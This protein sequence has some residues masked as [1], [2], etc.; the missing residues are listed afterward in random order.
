LGAGRRGRVTYGFT[1]AELLIAIGIFALVMALL[2]LPLF[3]AFGY[4]QKA[5]ARSEAQRAGIKAIR[6]FSRDIGTAQYLFDIPPDGSW[7]AFLKEQ[8]T[9]APDSTDADVRAARS[10]GMPMDFADKVTL[11]RYALTPAFPWVWGKDPV[12]NKD[13]WLL[14]TPTYLAAQ[15]LPV[16]AP[17]LSTQSYDENYAPYHDANRMGLTPNPYTITRLETEPLLWRDAVTAAQN[18]RYPLDAATSDL[19]GADPSTLPQRVAR[20][21]LI[22][23]LRN[24]LP[25]I[26]PYGADTWD[27][28]TFQVTPLRVTSEALIPDRLP[29][30]RVDVT[31]FSASRPLWVG[32]SLDLDLAD[33]ADFADAYLPPGTTLAAADIWTMATEAAP[34]YPRGV[35]PFGYQV[36]IFNGSGELQYG[37]S[38]YNAKTK[39]APLLCLRHFLDWPLIDR[40][41][42][43]ETSSAPNAV[44]LDKFVPETYGTTLPNPWQTQSDRALVS[45]ALR[46][47][48][49]RQRLEGKLV[50]AQPVA[51]DVLDF[52]TYTYDP[53][54]PA[55][56]ELPRPKGA[57]WDRY[58]AIAALPARLT[59][60]DTATLATVTFTYVNKSLDSLGINEYTRLVAPGTAAYAAASGVARRSVVFGRAMDG[61]WQV[62]YAGL[63]DDGTLS[64]TTLPLAD[65]TGGGQSPVPAGWTGQ[66][67]PAALP[68]SLYTL[69]DLQA[70]DTGN[71]DNKGDTVVA[72]YSTK[73]V[74]DVTMAVSRKDYAA[75]SPAKSRQ[76]YSQNLRIE[77]RNAMKRARGDE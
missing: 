24:N 18:G 14:E 69:C 9:D 61:V 22:R 10:L 76:D 21:Q 41:P 56:Y 77:A 60:R 31:T 30:G 74:L 51:P 15:A 36:R 17:Y 73:A 26:T 23:R 54:N 46:N 2:G 25:S 72:T 58:A 16:G 8:G 1:L 35:N 49:A 3:S 53:D 20:E 48:V 44:I 13:A 4:V 75:T 19:Y 32:R 34:L 55:G 57:G 37:T 59:L 43:L 38:V 67:V 6:A 70:S 65:G 64:Y 39:T 12:S 45:L 68:V 42:V 63:E 52:D 27:A 62:R 7:V 50:F 66:A 29:D 47:L 33:A 5:M 28:P 71:P 11:I 40:S